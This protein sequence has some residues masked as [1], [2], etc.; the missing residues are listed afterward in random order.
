MYMK[1]LLSNP[2]IVLSIAAAFFFLALADSM[3]TD[4]SSFSDLTY[5]GKV[6]VVLF[7]IPF[8]F[9]MIKY[10]VVPIGNAIVN[11]FK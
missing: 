7:L 1:N 2:K 4:A 9:L 8:I 11:W 5:I 3:E 6:S 10:M